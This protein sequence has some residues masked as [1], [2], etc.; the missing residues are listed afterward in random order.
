MPEL[1]LLRHAKSSWDDPGLRD[2]D[3][4]LNERGGR[5]APRMGELLRDEHILPDRI[6][7]STAVRARQTAEAVAAVCGLSDALATIEE[8]YL[9]PP[10]VILET[11]RRRAGEAIR[12]LVVAHNPGLEELVARLA[13]QHYEFPTAALARFRLRIDSWE[14]LDM[15]VQADLLGLWRPRELDGSLG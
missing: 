8:L 7:S 2:H 3:R 14:R 4:P 15:G 9:A 11:V 5:A 6:L 10:S 12:V 1:L 13:G